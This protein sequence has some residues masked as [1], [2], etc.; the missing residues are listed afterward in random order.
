MKQYIYIYI[1]IYFLGSCSLPGII[2]MCGFTA[3]FGITAICGFVAIFG[4]TAI[5]GIVA[6]FGITA[7]YGIVA[8]FGIT[9]ICGIVAINWYYSHFVALHHLFSCPILLSFQ[10]LFHSIP[11]KSI[12]ASFGHKAAQAQQVTLVPD[13]PGSQVPWPPRRRPWRAQRPAR[14]NMLVFHGLSK[15]KYK[16][17]LFYKFLNKSSDGAS[18]FSI[19]KNHDNPRDKYQKNQSI[20]LREFL[21]PGSWTQVAILYIV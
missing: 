2:A 11:C 14:H 8:I 20:H 19:P 17:Y 21:Q 4:I 13:Q 16:Y 7:I 3:I 12:A 5:C 1:Y 18:T 9:A 15:T 6:I 10:N